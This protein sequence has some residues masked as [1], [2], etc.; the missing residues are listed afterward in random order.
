MKKAKYT[1]EDLN[2]APSKWHS[3]NY[4]WVIMPIQDAWFLDTAEWDKSQFL[5]EAGLVGAIFTSHLQAQN[6]LSGALGDWI[7]FQR[8]SIYRSSDQIISLEKTLSNRWIL[9]THV[10]GHAQKLESLSKNHPLLQAH[11]TRQKA[12]N[13]INQHRDLFKDH[14]VN[15]PV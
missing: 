8:A 4:K 11:A 13:C 9:A 10:F 7:R 6:A 3:L 15:T 2:L 12:L 5:Y 1:I 14:I